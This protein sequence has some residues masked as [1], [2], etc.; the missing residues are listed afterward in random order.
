MATCLKRFLQVKDSFT[1]IG[2]FEILRQG[3]A[4]KPELGQNSCE[5]GI[6]RRRKPDYSAQYEVKYVPA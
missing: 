2:E 6:D 3:S 5:F 4:K 1:P